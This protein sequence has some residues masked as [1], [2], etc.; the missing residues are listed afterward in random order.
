MPWTDIFAAWGEDDIPQREEIVTTL[1]TDTV[2]YADPH[3]GPVDGR[4]GLLQVIAG[5][6]QAMPDGS[7][8][9]HHADGY[10]GHVRAA[11]DFRRDG[12]AFMTG[13]YVA[14]LNADGA[15]TR[16]VGFASMPAS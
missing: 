8:A 14:E 9:A 12:Q 6:R 4:D 5:F 16:L 1:A 13:Q 3:S 7:A 15:I 2:H 11:V 10:Q